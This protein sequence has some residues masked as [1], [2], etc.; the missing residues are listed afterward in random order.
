MV[1]F[2]SR[3]EAEPSIE[4]VVAAPRARLTIE[5]WGASICCGWL[6]NHQWHFTLAFV[7][8]ALSFHVDVLLYRPQQ[9]AGHTID[10]K[11]VDQSWWISTLR[12]QARLAIIIE[13]IIPPQRVF[14]ILLS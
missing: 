9:I 10:G 13:L 2:F 3:V 14:F 6:A 12:W 1:P 5:V 4:A 11:R 8:D 7:Q